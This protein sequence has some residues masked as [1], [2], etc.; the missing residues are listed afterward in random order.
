GTYIKRLHVETLPLDKCSPHDLL[1]IL[2]HC[3]NLE[4]FEDWRSVRRAMFRLVV[5]GDERVPF[6]S[7]GMGRHVAARPLKRVCWTN[8]DYDVG[9]FERGGGLG[10]SEM[11]MSTP[12]LGMGVSGA[13]LANLE[14]ELQMNGTSSTSMHDAQAQ[15]YTLTL[16]ALSSLKATLDN[17]TF[18]IL[19]TWDLPVL[20]NLSV[21]AAD[22]GYAGKGFKRFFEVHGGKVRQLELGH[23]SGE[24][25]EWWV[26]VNPHANPN[27]QP[28]NTD[29]SSSPFA[30]PLNTYCP[31][32]TEFICCA[33]AEWNWTSPDWIAP[34]VLMPRHEGL[35]VIGV[36]G[37]E[38]RLRGD[39][40]EAVGRRGGDVD[41]V[42]E[43]G[44]SLR[45]AL[46]LRGLREDPYFMLLQQF[47]SL[48][49]REAF[50][51]LLKVRDMSP[52]SD[53]VR[54]VVARA[55]GRIVGAFWERVVERCEARG[56][57]L[58]DWRGGEVRRGAVGRCDRE[59][60]K[61]CVGGGLDF[62][63]GFWEHILSRGFLLVLI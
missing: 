41:E 10:G 37:L 11:G 14:L 38:R 29:A 45:A 22:F 54:R 57:V 27:N 51:G 17:A 6:A 55:N 33:D 60:G 26:V 9:D 47:G 13:S 48:L 1:L 44:M 58:E 56:V 19:S 5:G 20:R 32:L 21:I 16:P 30:V 62:T 15:S 61:A 31:N 25:E 52:E 7:E 46:R 2:Q 34:H 43:R 63:F 49:R 4:V 28:P 24:V 3:P 35:E 53:W 36:R 18:F 12:T 59:E 40:G 42:G 50:P 39:L 23:S 8:Y